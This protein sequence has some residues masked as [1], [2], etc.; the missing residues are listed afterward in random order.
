MQKSR[1]YSSVECVN[2]SIGLKDF[3]ISAKEIFSGSFEIPF[4]LFACLKIHISP[5]WSVS[6]IYPPTESFSFAEKFQ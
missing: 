3:L 1:K 5:L 2:S 4:L 6:I